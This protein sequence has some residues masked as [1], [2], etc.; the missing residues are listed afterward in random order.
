MLI[1]VCVCVCV[2][3]C[4]TAFCDQCIVYVGIQSAVWSK[5]GA[6]LV[7]ILPC[8]LPLL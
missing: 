5:G 8:V 6:V 3:V 2:C 4:V 1:F 7:F